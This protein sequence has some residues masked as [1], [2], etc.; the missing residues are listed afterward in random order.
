[1]STGH[2]H[3]HGAAGFNAAFAI[4]IGLNM[5]FVVVEAFYGWRINSLAL[6]ADAGHNLSDVIG[7]VLAW[8][9][10]LASRLRP[11]A[12]HT[13]GWKRASILAAFINA[14]LLLVAMG[15]LAWEAVHRL[16][17]PEPIDG[18]TIM[19]VAG[20][21]IVVNTITALLFM[22][23]REGDLNIRGA[24]LHMAADAL[25]SA[26]VVVAG[27]L[28]LWF[29]WTWLDPVASL[30]IA[31][32]IVVGTASLFKQSLHLLFDGVPESVD[33]H[34]VQA[35]LEALPGV[36][37]VHD[38]HVWA[39]GTSE[40]AMTAHLVMPEGHADDAFLQRATGQLH[41]RFGIEHVTLQVMR[42]PFTTPC[43]RS[44]DNTRLSDP[45]SVPRTVP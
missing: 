6:L 39:M 2:D 29:G 5:A 11:N 38:L 44:D 35:L 4:G 18:L 36:A 19:L 1:M 30:V 27:S 42:V 34:E 3:G 17:S 12:R 21:G 41:D 15:S 31:A 9:A 25:V 43:A 16:Q 13:Y 28:T 45:R 10:A 8:G 7:L 33:L 37:R 22:R 40:I 20:V 24:F 32:V 26:G 14:L 23:G